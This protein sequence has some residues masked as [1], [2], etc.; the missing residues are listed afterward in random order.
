MQQLPRNA[1][2]N[3]TRICL[4]ITSVE[5]LIEYR[6]LQFF[7]Q[8]CRLSGI[9]LAKEIFNYRLTRY[10]NGFPERFGFI[11][12]IYRILCKYSLT[13]V[14]YNYLQ[15]S[16]FPSKWQWK[17][18]LVKAV[19]KSENQYQIDCIVSAGHLWVCNNLIRV[20]QCSSLWFV[21]R[22]TPSLSHICRKLSRN[23]A[24]L[25]SRQ[26]ERQCTKCKLNTEKII[27]H[28]ICLCIRNNRE[29]EN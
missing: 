29:R 15:S 8:L 28:Q 27:L 10:H 21:S 1:S 25:V 17:D 11:P 26:Y 13:D 9:F 20:S 2:S 3:Y 22:N 23:I 4:N 7:G 14:M 16:L 6:K 24:L 18:I 12:D 5:T 19:L